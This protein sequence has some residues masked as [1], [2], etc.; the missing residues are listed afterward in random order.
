MRIIHLIDYFQP[1]I[2]YQETFLAREHQK[3]GHKVTVVTSDC[4]FPF[5][6]YSMSVG[7]ILGQRKVGSGETI[8]E[9]IT[10]IRLPTLEFPNTNQLFLHDLEDCIKNLRPDIVFCHGMHSLTSWRIATM[11]KR[12]KYK[13]IFDT[14]AASFNTKLTNTLP[15]KLYHSLFYHFARPQIIKTADAIFAIGDGERDFICSDFNLPPKKVP[16]IRLGVDIN[17][18]NYSSKLRQEI[19][20]K[21]HISKENILIIYAGKITPNKDVD[22]LCKA[23]TLLN[24]NKI[25]LLLIGGG[26]KK[27]LNS[28]HQLVKDTINIPFV[29]NKDLPAYYSAA[30]LGVWPGDFSI[31]LL[32]AMAC[33]L[34][35][36]LP[37]NIDSSYLN[38]SN[39][40]WRFSRGNHRDL[41]KLIQSITTNK[42]LIKKKGRY[43]QKYIRNYLSWSKIA[44]KTIDLWKS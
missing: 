18:F 29:L 30:D 21:L 40:V 10:T 25:R 41:G 6:H 44:K 4:Y 12:L 36:V 35:L 28:L 16:I 15:K 43:A 8:E 11:K 38:H 14:H 39:A 27:Y 34:P 37:Y 23:V 7:N 9:G 19:R 1:K 20:K 33:K 17:L 3:L 13:L 5:P 22:T 24:L 31:T 42:Y 2:G 32:E 26:D